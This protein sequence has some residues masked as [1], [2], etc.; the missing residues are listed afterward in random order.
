MKNETSSECHLCGKEIKP[1]SAYVN[2]TRNVEQVEH[3]IMENEFEIQV[4]DSIEL[5]RL[6]GKCGN[7]F[8]ADLLSTIIQS[9]PPNKDSRNLN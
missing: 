3:N 7:A 5:I 4:I 2:I 6:C 9:I 1:G 8:D